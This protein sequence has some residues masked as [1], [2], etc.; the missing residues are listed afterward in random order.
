M[1]ETLIREL[2]EEIGLEPTDY[3]IGRQ[4]GCIK[5]DITLTHGGLST[6]L[7]LVVYLCTLQSEN[8]PITIVAP[9][10]KSSEWMD[11]EQMADAFEKYSSDFMTQ[12]A[13][14]R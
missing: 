14:L 9:E 7:F 5:T 3:T 4:L 1:R 8:H 10:N 13:S 2:H 6:A 12:L 11:T